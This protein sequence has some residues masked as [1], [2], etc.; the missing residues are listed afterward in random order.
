MAAA[1]PRSVL[2]QHVLLTFGELHARGTA[3]LDGG[4]AGTAGVGRWP[5]A[6][7]TAPSIWAAR[8]TFQPETGPPP[9]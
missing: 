7:F 4:A 5:I 2:L 8:S 3:A 6:P 9:A 1:F